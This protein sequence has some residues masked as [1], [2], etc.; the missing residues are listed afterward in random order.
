[1][2]NT[3]LSP[4]LQSSIPVAGSNRNSKI[5]IKGICKKFESLS[6]MTENNVNVSESST[7]IVP[8]RSKRLN[9][10]SEAK[11]S[12]SKCSNS[13]TEVL[14]AKSIATKCDSNSSVKERTK[15]FES[16]ALNEKSITCSTNSKL[17]TEK[18]KTAVAKLKDFQ[19]SAEFKKSEKCDTPPAKP[20][21]TFTHSSSSTENASK[22]NFETSRRNTVIDIKVK[23]TLKLESK[24]KN[25]SSF[26]LEQKIEAPVKNSR[27]GSAPEVLK[28]STERDFQS[29]PNSSR[30]S[31][32]PH[33]LFSYL[34][35]ISNTANNIREKVKQTSI[36]VDLT[37]TTVSP[38]KH[39]GTLKR[40]M[41]EEH[42]YAE[43]VIKASEVDKAK[44]P[45]AEPLH[46]MV[47][48]FLLNF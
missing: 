30:T 35:N 17:I 4:P 12:T 33:V 27:L 11:N 34:K 48:N 19:N 7:P 14:S 23:P 20:P 24:A 22:Y 43:P 2:S 8:A 15:L 39:Y 16:T 29:T 5:D 25:A 47:I 21:R 28:L 44:S 45:T 13:N 32:K 9:R 38:P 6:T 40:S 3:K 10:N 41:S 46:Y 18:N 31:G 1:M 26:S 42:I 36:F 37:P